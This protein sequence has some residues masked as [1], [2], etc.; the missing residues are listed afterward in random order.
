MILGLAR[1]AKKPERG[2]PLIVESFW[3]SHRT[4]KTKI[5]ICAAKVAKI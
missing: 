5:G 4:R 2:W 3:Q 1:K